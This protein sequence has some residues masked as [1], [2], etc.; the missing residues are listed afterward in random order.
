MRATSANGLKPKMPSSTG[1]PIFSANCKAEDRLNM[2]VAGWTV[3]VAA[4]QASTGLTHI[5]LHTAYY[6]M[7]RAGL[8]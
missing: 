5:E 7:G 3:K 1:R 8:H 6:A 4:G 2:A